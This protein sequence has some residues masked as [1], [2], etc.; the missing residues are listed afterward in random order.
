MKHGKQPTVVQSKLM[1][2]RHLKPADWF[3][4][5]DTP[6]EMHIVHRHFDNVRK[7]IVKGA[8]ID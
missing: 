8:V 2:R 3:V 7:A 6:T 5:K 4:G 1:Q